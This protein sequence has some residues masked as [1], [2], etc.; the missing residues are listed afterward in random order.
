MGV[1]SLLQDPGFDMS[2]VKKHAETAHL[3][4]KEPKFRPT[5]EKLMGLP[6]KTQV[7]NVA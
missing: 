2:E 1:Y 6:P 7:F 3:W 5:G 4:Y